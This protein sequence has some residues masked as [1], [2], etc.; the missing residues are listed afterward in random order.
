MSTSSQERIDVFELLCPDFDNTL[1]S[2]LDQSGITVNPVDCSEDQADTL[3]K[4]V[5]TL[6]EDCTDTALTFSNSIDIIKKSNFYNQFYAKWGKSIALSLVLEQLLTDLMLCIKPATT[7][8]VK[9]FVMQ[10]LF[11]KAIRTYMEINTLI[12]FGF[13][14]GAIALV[15]V[16]Y[17]LWICFSF[18][19]TNNS[20]VATAYLKKAAEPL[21]KRSAHDNYDWAKAATCF[22][23][24]TD[25]IKLHE[26]H[27]KVSTDDLLKIES[28]N[29]A[30]YNKFIHAAPQTINDTPE[31]D[32]ENITIGPL[33]E[34]IQI[35][36]IHSTFYICQMLHV[37]KNWFNTGDL[38][39]RYAFCIEWIE[40]LLESYSKTADGSLSC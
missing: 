16:L 25:D 6:A 38:F 18:I 15:R 8:D 9:E 34:M 19:A 23:D 1:K 30:A 31:S 4:T 26:L 27:K 37:G 20:S 39:Q 28:R 17:E 22:C 35:P 3:I 21:T 7:A 13:P 12:R 36:A 32:L 11:S 24:R 10:K 14:N 29:Y 2:R 40:I 33:H 5:H